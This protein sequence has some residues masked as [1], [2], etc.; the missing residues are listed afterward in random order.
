M[1][2]KGCNE[3]QYEYIT[4]ESSLDIPTSLYGN[5]LLDTLYQLTRLA[6][7]CNCHISEING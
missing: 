3:I 6:M 2:F 1:S 7:Q 4:R 5:T